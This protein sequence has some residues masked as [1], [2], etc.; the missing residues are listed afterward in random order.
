KPKRPLIP[1]AIFAIAQF[2][3]AIYVMDPADGAR[4]SLP[5]MIAISLLVAAGL[6]VVRKSMQLRAAT[7]IA[8]AVLATASI[9]HTWPIVGTR[10]VVP[11][12]PAAAAAY[13]NTHFAPN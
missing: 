2:I 11:S 1:I 3:F 6:H 8:V 4:Y 10:R 12:P 13:A 7:W 9:A 5:H